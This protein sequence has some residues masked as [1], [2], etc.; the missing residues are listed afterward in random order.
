M[1]PESKFLGGD[2]PSVKFGLNITRPTG[3]CESGRGMPLHQCKTFKGQCSCFFLDKSWHFRPEDGFPASYNNNQLLIA[4]LFM[5]IKQAVQVSYFLY[6]DLS[7][8]CRTFWWFVLLSYFEVK[9]LVFFLPFHRFRTVKGCGYWVSRSYY[10]IML[11]II[12]IRLWLIEI[13][14]QSINLRSYV[15]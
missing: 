11:I 10:L 6:D 13:I 7:Y 2:A 4:S 3:G 1:I 15:W 9:F 8:F 14:I 5:F 12:E